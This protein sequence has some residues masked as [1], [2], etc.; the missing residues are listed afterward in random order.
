MEEIAIDP[1]S[2]YIIDPCTACKMK[3]G[4]EDVNINELN[5]CVTETAAAFTQ[6]PT[7]LA[8]EKGDAMI[9]WFRVFFPHFRGLWTYK[10]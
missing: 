5:D 3:F 9:N 10:A 7:N 1:C 8:V 4:N 6:F 2:S